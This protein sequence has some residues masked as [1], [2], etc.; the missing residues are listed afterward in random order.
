MSVETFER[1]LA[2]LGR[3]IVASSMARPYRA[4]SLALKAEGRDLRDAA[5]MRAL[6]QIISTE[7]A[8]R[9]QRWDDEELGHLVNFLADDGLLTP[10]MLQLVAVRLP[11]MNT[12]R[13]ISALRFL[14]GLTT[15][16]LPD[17]AFT[18]WGR[19]MA[20]C[21]ARHVRRS[22]P[23]YKAPGLLLKAM[24][25]FKELSFRDDP[26]LY[27]ALAERCLDC[28]PPPAE[29]L[30]P[31]WI[32]GI[33]ASLAAAGY[34]SFRLSPGYTL[35]VTQRA[36]PPRLE[37]RLADAAIRV[38]PTCSGS[39]LASIASH[40][41]SMGLM[42]SQAAGETP[43]AAAAAATD[44]LWLTVQA[45]CVQL[46]PQLTA[47]DV[48]YICAAFAS[49]TR[50]VA[51][52]VIG[53]ELAAQAYAAATTGGEGGSM[54]PRSG[55][56]S[57]AE[58]G[59]VIGDRRFWRALTAAAA[60]HVDAMNAH[61]IGL[62]LSSLATVGEIDDALFRDMMRRLRA[63]A[64]GA[65]DADGGGDGDESARCNARFSDRLIPTV[66][67]VAWALFRAGHLDAFVDDIAVLS[68]A[69]A[70][71]IYDDTVNTGRRQ[72][73][74]QPGSPPPGSAPR[75]HLENCTLIF[76]S[77]GQAA[78]LFDA[79]PPQLAPSPALGSALRAVAVATALRVNL[80]GSAEEFPPDA[81]MARLAQSLE[82][83][84][85]RCV[86]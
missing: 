50:R 30:K 29:P 40:L 73:Q 62:V 14:R 61:E 37:A 10:E 83:L 81:V 64:E 28:L 34:R 69:A 63:A 75:V 36:L 41:G 13:S 57:A 31:E 51:H 5:P 3:G 74:R 17:A 71:L 53:E 56:R 77:V 7:L 8:N 6:L 22:L 42:A 12:I 86:F 78:G 26:A 38:I 27:E 59:A 43:T 16:P 79:H 84:L 55:P 23:Y 85:P 67:N 9:S 18:P 48:V 82:L 45:R 32:R 11:S 46:L 72:Q 19:E 60:V 33:L 76:R 24:L 65:G 80:L 1:H 44:R 2:D 49:A 58:L 66:A 21:V 39:D 35:G 25:E 70:R 20:A 15:L 52:E 4:L 68:S 54:E 47:M